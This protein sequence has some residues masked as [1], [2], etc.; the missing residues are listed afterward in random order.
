MLVD[1]KGQETA[2]Q[3]QLNSIGEL[4]KL[5]NDSNGLNR[6]LSML[7]QARGA[8]KTINQHTDKELS[9][10][11]FEVKEKFPPAQKMKCS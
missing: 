6:V 4:T 10:T 2:I 5:T 7:T 9:A 1:I 3:E 8:L 11:H